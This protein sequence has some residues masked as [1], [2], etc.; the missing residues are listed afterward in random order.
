MT[1]TDAATSTVTALADLVTPAAAGFLVVYLVLRAAF[2]LRRAYLV[3][4]DVDR[5]LHLALHPSRAHADPACVFCA[6]LLGSD[7]P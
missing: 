6:A 1:P 2:A 7:A 3:R 4:W 5:T